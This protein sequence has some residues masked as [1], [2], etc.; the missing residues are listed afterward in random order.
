MLK[1]LPDALKSANSIAFGKSTLQ[2][3]LMCLH[4]FPQH[5]SPLCGQG[6]SGSK[7][8]EDTELCSTVMK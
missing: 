6:G 5:P 7:H 3:L 4:S 8:S 2:G 1:M